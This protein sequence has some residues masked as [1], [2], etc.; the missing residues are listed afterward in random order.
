MEKGGSPSVG[1]RP[2]FQITRV[3]L[4][5]ARQICAKSCFK[6]TT[7]E[8]PWNRCGS[9]DIFWLRGKDLNLRPPGYEPD[10]LPNCSTPRYG[11][12]DRGRTG[13]GSLPRDF[14]SRASANSAT[15]AWVASD[16]LLKARIVYHMK[17]TMSSQKISF[18]FPIVP[19]GWMY[20]NGHISP[21]GPHILICISL[22]PAIC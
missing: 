17:W 14:K 19:L 2:S 22:L 12:G 8:N 15:P 4:W 21:Q 13:T 5:L 1:R 11:A 6:Q 7:K 9:R 10:E 20:K 18:L 3:F 16:L